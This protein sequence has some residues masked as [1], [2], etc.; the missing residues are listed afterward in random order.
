MQ[1]KTNANKARARRDA[2][3]LREQEA[4]WASWDD[5]AAAA[6][7]QSLEAVGPAAQ[8]AQSADAAAAA[9]DGGDVVAAH[10]GALTPVVH[11]PDTNAVVFLADNLPPWML[12]SA[13]QTPQA[14]RSGSPWR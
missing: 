10:G 5:Q 6:A 8:V 11:T 4:M 2:E 12:P 7:L 9:G 13:S 1:K 14:A 3:A